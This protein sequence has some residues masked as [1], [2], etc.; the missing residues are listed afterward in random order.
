MTHTQLSDFDAQ[1]SALLIV[2]MQNDYLHQDGGFQR[3]ALSHPHFGWDMDGL[4]ATVAPIAKLS[5]A[6]R[7][8]SRPVIYIVMAHDGA[9]A[10]ALKWARE[11][12][13]ATAAA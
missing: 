7:R 11:L 5:D 9:Y 4:R 8:C 1:R 10:D 13:V 2:D 6:F 3:F 12:S